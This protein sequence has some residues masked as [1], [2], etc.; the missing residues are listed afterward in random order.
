MCS[1][2]HESD[3][4]LPEPLARSLDRDGQQVTAFVPP[5]YERY[6][7]VLN[8]IEVPAGSTVMWADVVKRGGLQT[9]PWMQMG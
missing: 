8:P 2:R 1:R 6:V 5:G 7:R 9:S 4:Q 3:R